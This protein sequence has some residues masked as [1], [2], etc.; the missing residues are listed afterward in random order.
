VVV[1]ELVVLAVE[2]VDTVVAVATVADIN[3]R[4]V[5]LLKLVAVAVVAA[6]AEVLGIGLV[7]RQEGAALVYLDKEPMEL[8]EYQIV[9]VL[10]PLRQVVLEDLEEAMAVVLVARLVTR[11]QL[12]QVITEEELDP[13]PSVLQVE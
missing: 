3:D 5:Q 7:Q 9:V 2:L 8:V 1:V 10:V 11:H 12:D 13:F 4:D 6:E